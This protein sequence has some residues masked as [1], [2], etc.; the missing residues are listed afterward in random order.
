MKSRG[1][2]RLKGLTMYK[3]TWLLP[4]MK[5]TQKCTAKTLTLGRWAV[6][7]GCTA[8]PVERQVVRREL[9][10]SGYIW[11]LNIRTCQNEY[12]AGHE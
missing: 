6:L 1:P 9:T 5:P 11:G 12:L 2:H 8:H 4:L 7:S 3:S 10:L